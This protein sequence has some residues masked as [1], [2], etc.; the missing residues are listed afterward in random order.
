MNVRRIALSAGLT[1]CLLGAGSTALA[2]SATPSPG[3]IRVFLTG[4]SDT[5]ADITITG[6]IGDHGTG[7]SED[8][9]GKVDANGNF[10]KVTLKQGGF[11]IDATVLDKKSTQAFEHTPINPANCS[12]AVTATGST[13]IEDGTGAYAGITGKVTVTFVFA[14]AF[15]KT[16]KGC[17]MSS[18]PITY[19]GGTGSGSVSFK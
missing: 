16:A 4:V 10:E 11:R 18:D 15:P 5:K 13:I 14:G 19:Q 1:T 9:N 12:L 6:A 3:K 17:D 7:I 2:A 8:A